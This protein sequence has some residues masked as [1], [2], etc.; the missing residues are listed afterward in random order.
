M[1]TKCCLQQGPSNLSPDSTATCPYV[2]VES[3]A[4]PHCKATS[5]SKIHMHLRSG[6]NEATL[7]A[8]FSNI[9]CHE[10]H[11]REQ[12]ETYKISIMQ[13]NCHQ[14]LTMSHCDFA[15]IANDATSMKGN[16][17]RIVHSPSSAALLMSSFQVLQKKPLPSPRTSP[18]T[19][20]GGPTVQS[21]SHTV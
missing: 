12:W 18:V 13:M 21:A 14:L 6:C 7:Q 3:E 16:V 20:C 1:Q 9:G 15:Q 2:R 8:G 4:G 10:S 17:T 5:S 11:V 19:M